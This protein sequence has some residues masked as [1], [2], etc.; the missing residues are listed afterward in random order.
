MLKLTIRLIAIICIVL[1][2]NGCWDNKDID[3]RLMPIVM[4]ITKVNEEYKVILQIP[5][6]VQDRIENRIIQETGKTITKAIDKLSMNMENDIDLLHVKVIMIERPLA[7]EG[8]NDTISGF[9]RARDVSPD[10]LVVICDQ[11]L[12]QFFSSTSKK[13][14]A[15]AKNLYNFFEKNAGWTPQIVLTRVWQ[16]YRSIHSYT[17]DVAIPILI[18]GESTMVEHLGSAIIKNGKMVEQITSDETLLLNA[19][20]GESAQGR[21]EV[22]DHGSVLIVSNTISHESRFINNEPHLKS[23][24]NL[25][26]VILETKGDP[27]IE[28]IQKELTTLLTERFERMFNKIQQSEADVLALGQFFR[29][30]IPREQLK[31]WRSEYYPQL[32]MDFHVQ[33]DIQNTGMLKMN[34]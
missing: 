1:L 29:G 33:I 8:V 4:G 6:P 28:L 22:M 25:K 9:L 12:D 11:D 23:I 26:V 31:K 27:S 30:S 20:N 2:L 18:S 5:E 17:Q 19:F 15:E 3:H 34:N 10:A 24:I 13:L 14:K 16:V 7:E 21:I 32:K